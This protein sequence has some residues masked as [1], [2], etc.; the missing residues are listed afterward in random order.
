MKVYDERE[1]FY[2]W[3]LNQ[4]I[5]SQL[6]KEGDEVH[7]GQSRSSVA[8]VVKT[9]KEGD[10][11]VADVPNVLLQS[12]RKIFAFQYVKDGERE[13]TTNERTFAII[14]RPKP[15]DYVYTE[16][17]ILRVE[18]YVRKA[19]KKE[20]EN[21]VFAE[22]KKEVIEA[23]KQLNTKS[24]VPRLSVLEEEA[25]KDPNY[26]FA[27]DFAGRYNRLYM[28][29]SG[30]GWD[31]F[32][33]GMS[34]KCVITESPEPVYDPDACDYE[35]DENGNPCGYK[36]NSIPVRLADGNIRVS[37]DIA[38][39]ENTE[40]PESVRNEYAVS[41]K[42]AETL[43]NRLIKSNA[44]GSDKSKHYTTNILR[45]DKTTDTFTPAV[46]GLFH[47]CNDADAKKSEHIP[48]RASDGSMTCNVPTTPGLRHI[49]NVGYVNEK[50][51]DIDKALDSILAIQ[52]KILGG[53][54]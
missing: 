10:D 26:K 23:V 27:Y 44:Y 40:I 3:D 5:K 15:E 21:G 13:Y 50:L 8:L 1:A 37:S 43:I 51:G 36:L 6:F 53:E 29:K 14:P 32:G 17:E 25:Q 31:G 41:K 46:L 33:G 47:S 54:A 24:F 16:T 28:E 39:F 4:K 48:L 9:Y 11:I 35:T 49:A 12:T 19:L 34:Y 45:Y 38:S 22:W 52:N 18:D 2:Q 42:V 20:K 30:D 7:F